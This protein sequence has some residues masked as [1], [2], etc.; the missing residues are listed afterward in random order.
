[1][2]EFAYTARGLDGHNVT[3]LL[4]AGSRREA[5]ASLAQRSLFLLKLDDHTDST[6]TQRWTTAL[7]TRKRVRPEQ[8]ANCLS[9]LSDLLQN[10][11]PLLGSLQLLAEQSP[12]PALREVMTDVRDQVADG[13]SLEEA[14]AR[15]PRVSRR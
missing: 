10:G 15:H 2:P 12:N 4:T 6:T 1:M 7:T 9:Q 11:V 8:V 13:S 3:G 14:V 5:M